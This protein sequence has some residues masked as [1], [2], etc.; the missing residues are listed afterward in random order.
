MTDNVVERTAC[1][2][3]ALL[4]AIKKSNQISQSFAVPIIVT[5]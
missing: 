3:L 5:D 2:I 1:L 4:T